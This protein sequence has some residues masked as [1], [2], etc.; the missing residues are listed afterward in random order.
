VIGS[1]LA[2][3]WDMADHSTEKRFRIQSLLN[4]P[5]PA[6]LPPELGDLARAYASLLKQ[7]LRRTNIQRLSHLLD[8][9]DQLVLNAYDL[10]P[11]LTRALLASFTGASRPVAHEW[12]PWAVSLDDPALSLAEIRSG[13]LERARGNWPHDKL[14][15]LPSNEAAE[16]APYLP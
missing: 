6:T 7:R 14:K 13:V 1:K 12:Q 10:P 15:P 9:I 3:A 4:V 8:Q 16:A 2:A 5:V 11:R